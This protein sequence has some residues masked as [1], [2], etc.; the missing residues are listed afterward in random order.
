MKSF[1]ELPLIESGPAMAL[2][3]EDGLPACVKMDDYDGPRGMAEILA[4]SAP[5][6]DIKELRAVAERLSLGRIRVLRVTQ[7]AGA[8]HVLSP[9]DFECLEEEGLAI[10][11]ICDLDG[12]VVENPDEIADR[13]VWLATLF[14]YGYDPRWQQLAFYKVAIRRCGLKF[15]MPPWLQSDEAMLIA[16]AQPWWGFSTVA[17]TRQ[18]IEFA[19]LI[20]DHCETWEHATGVIRDARMWVDAMESE[21]VE[22]P[23]MFNV[24]RKTRPLAPWLAAVA[25]S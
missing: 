16:D 9:A 11:C 25:R 6:S 5:A 21:F 2:H 13:F 23:E 19:E 18:T 7:S 10:F 8:T 1:Y 24:F 20:A 4:K 3:I 14:Q 17:S 15:K 22:F 12:A